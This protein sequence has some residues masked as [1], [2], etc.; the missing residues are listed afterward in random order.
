MWPFSYERNRKSVESD[1]SDLMKRGDS[2]DL[3]EVRNAQE[4]N[5]TKIYINL[6]FL[7]MIRGNVRE[8]TL[9]KSIPLPPSKLQPKAEVPT[10]ESVVNR[11]KVMASLDPVIY[12]Q[13]REG[14][15]ELTLGSHA[16]VIIHMRFVD[17][18]PNRSVHL[19]LERLDSPARA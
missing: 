12:Q 1:L 11:L 16:V 13:P 4:K 2:I 19:R 18:A 14:L 5:P 3:E 17:Q 15:I 6:L 9:S 10:F 7:E 8:F